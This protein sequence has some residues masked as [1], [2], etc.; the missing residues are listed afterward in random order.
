MVLAEFKGFWKVCNI[1]LISFGS[2]SDS[3]RIDPQMHV[4]KPPTFKIPPKCFQ[5][6][7]FKVFAK[8]I[9]LCKLIEF[10]FKG[11]RGTIASF[12]NF[13]DLRVLPSQG[14]AA[15]HACLH[16]MPRESSTT[17][18]RAKHRQTTKKIDFKVLWPLPPPLEKSKKIK[19]YKSRTLEKLIKMWFSVGFGPI[20]DPDSNSA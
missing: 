15:E 17:C 12:R 1:F 6:K 9:S 7:D 3:T 18:A 16:V 10:N 8:N 19:F 2:L 13:T 20:L 11:A 5:D 14:R 4:V